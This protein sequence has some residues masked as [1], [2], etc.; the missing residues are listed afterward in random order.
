MKVNFLAQPLM[1]NLPKLP[2]LKLLELLKKGHFN[3]KRFRKS[4][5]DYFSR[6]I[7]D[8]EE[9]KRQLNEQ[10]TFDRAKSHIKEHYIAIK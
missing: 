8:L 5:V 2:N 1:K 9:A 4:F 6:L 7:D 3:L 10:E